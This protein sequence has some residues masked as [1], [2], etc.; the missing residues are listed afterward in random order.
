MNYLHSR[1]LFANVSKSVDFQNTADLYFGNISSVDV[2]KLL[3]A[4]NEKKEEFI[5]FEE[6]K[7]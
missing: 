7:S 5:L 3:G 6:K 4:E 2:P 1:F